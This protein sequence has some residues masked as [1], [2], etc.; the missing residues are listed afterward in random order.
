MFVALEV[1][2]LPLY[3]MCG[4]ARRRR[5]LSQE[6][7]VK[8][9][10]LGAFASAFF[11]YGLA[12]IYGVRGPRPARRHRDRVGRLGAVGHACCSPGS[13]CSSSACCSRRSV[14]A[15][16]HLDAGRLPGRADAGHGVHGGLHQGRRVR[17]DPA[18]ALRRRSAPARWDV[19]AGDL[20]AV[21]IVSMVVGAVLG[22]TQ[23]DIKRM[24]AYSSIAHAGFLLIGAMAITPA[25][26][27]RPR[28]STW[29]PTASP[30]SRAF[31]VITLVRDRGRRGHAPVAVGGPGQAVAADRGR[32]WRS[33]CSPSPASR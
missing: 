7:A 10:L 8:Y 21:A 29:S 18:R 27:L 2:S 17:R 30:R 1:L 20:W 31:G 23:T 4:L 12:L 15:V 25:G 3:L 26:R 6:A 9:F 5:L 28:C 16:P 32:S 22:L 19:A 33:S 13:R 24:L 14:G 11:L